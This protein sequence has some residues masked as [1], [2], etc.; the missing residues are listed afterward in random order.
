MKDVRTGH[1]PMPVV[2]EQQHTS[3]HASLEAEAQQLAS[4]TRVDRSRPS[5]PIVAPPLHNSA[6]R[7]QEHQQ[8]L[9]IH[10]QTELQLQTSTVM[11]SCYHAKQLTDVSIAHQRKR[12]SGHSSNPTTLIP[13]TQTLMITSLRVARNERRSTC[14]PPVT[15]PACCEPR[16]THPESQFTLGELVVITQSLHAILLANN[17]TSAMA[18]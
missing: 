11:Q 15:C 9:K 10:S 6:R 17:S 3:E 12:P 14:R 4:P 16:S 7:S 18:N 1:A 8:I 5:P 2:T 13:A